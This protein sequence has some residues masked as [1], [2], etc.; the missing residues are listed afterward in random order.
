MNI[1]QILGMP[2]GISLLLAVATPAW[3]AGFGNNWLEVRVVDRQSGAP[4]G[5]AAVC[6]GTAA[7]PDQFGARRATADGT[8]RFADL[9]VNRM[10]LTASY[11]TCYPRPEFCTDNGAMIAY[12]GYRRLQAGQSE[13][14]SIKAIPRWSLEE[15][16][17]AEG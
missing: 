12:A 11:R 15:L 2:A 6:L 13:G 16:V 14:L 4:V 8:V 3:S 10:L 9:P 7:R 5:Q 1:K 17:A